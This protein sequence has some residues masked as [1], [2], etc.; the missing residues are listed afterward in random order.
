MS[1]DAKD[2]TPMGEKAIGLIASYKLAR[3]KHAYFLM[4]ITGTAIGYAL[5]RAESMKLSWCVMFLALAVV[6]WFFSMVFGNRFVNLTIDSNVIEAEV[7]LAEI[8]DEKKVSS[9]RQ[10]LAEY[11]HHVASIRKRQEAFLLIGALFFVA[12]RACESYRITYVEPTATTY[13]VQAK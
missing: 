11:G 9:V 8:G 5:Q 6:S 1:E 12:W 2:I 7:Y 10:S 3:T 13:P 4:A